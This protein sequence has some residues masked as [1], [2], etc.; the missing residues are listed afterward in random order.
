MY[1]TCRTFIQYYLHYNSYLLLYALSKVIFPS[2]SW[3]QTNFKY[4][5]FLCDVDVDVALFA[6]GPEVM[7]WGQEP[8]RVWHRPS[9]CWVWE[10]A[11]RDGGC[12]GQQTL[13]GARDRCLQETPGGRREQVCTHDWNHCLIILT[14]ALSWHDVDMFVYESPDSQRLSWLP[15]RYHPPRSTLCAPWCPEVPVVEPAPVQEDSPLITS[16]STQPAAPDLLWLLRRQRPP[17]QHLK[18]RRRQ[19]V[20][21]LEAMVVRLNDAAPVSVRIAAMW[22]KM[23][24][25]S[26]DVHCYNV[27]SCISKKYAVWF[28]IL[29]M[30]RNLVIGCVCA[31][32]VLSCVLWL[33]AGFD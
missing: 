12:D 33:D 26:L 21:G 8:I 29:H 31:F 17:H 30:L 1:N 6:S 5:L 24:C 20:A 10:T 11:E 7:G 9:D 27:M 4:S 32:M 23:S 19:W 18:H 13:P 28:S 15:V 22:K 3:W 16:S 14:S 2:N 25:Y